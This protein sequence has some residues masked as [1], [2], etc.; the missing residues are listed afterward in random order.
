MEMVHSVD[1]LKS[2]S[3]SVRG[4]RMP[5][6]EVLDARIASALNKIIHN[7]HFKRRIG[8]EEKKA[9]TAD[10]FLHSR[11]IA[12]L[13]YEY[14]RVTGANDSVENLCRPVHYCSSK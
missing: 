4:I 9:Q 6:F 11:Q 5:Y 10:R 1:D 12:Y 14:F 2:S 7:S 13:I 3:S 8:L